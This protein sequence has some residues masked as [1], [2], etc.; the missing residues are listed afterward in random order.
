MRI[1]TGFAGGTTGATATPVDT[2]AG[3]TGPATDIV[4]TTSAGLNTAVMVALL[5]LIGIAVLGLGY[6]IGRRSRPAVGPPGGGG[7]GRGTPTTVGHAGVDAP[8][9]DPV[10]REPADS[11]RA[12]LVESLIDTRD[13]LHGNAQADRIG[14]ALAAA[15]VETIDP[16]GQHF[17]PNLHWAQGPDRVT[18]DPALDNTIA[19]TVTVGYVDQGVVHRL[20]GV[21]VYKLRFEER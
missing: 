8:D 7:I 3:E 21:I 5:L 6:L 10:P 16:T 9:P 12:S 4:V 14:K 15:G 20:P 19:E 18:D 11:Q 17:D 2:P 1:R 13:R